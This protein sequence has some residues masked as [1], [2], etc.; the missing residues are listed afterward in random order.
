MFFLYESRKLDKVIS[1]LPQEVLKRYEKWKDIVRISGLE[2]LRTMKGF[3]DE[4]L[5]GAWRGCRSSRLGDK[6][7]VLYSVDNKSSV[8]KIIDLTAHDYRK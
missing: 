6:Y 8:I 3:H 2:G 1:K 4:K 5:S 7:R